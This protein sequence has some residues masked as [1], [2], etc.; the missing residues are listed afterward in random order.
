MSDWIDLKYQA[1]LVQVL[2]SGPVVL[3]LSVEQ[4][5]TVV[6]LPRCGRERTLAALRVTG[7]CMPQKQTS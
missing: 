4:Q 7:S 5:T 3:Q 6:Q 1:P 2:F